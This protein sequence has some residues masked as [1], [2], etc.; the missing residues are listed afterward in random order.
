MRGQYP[1]G[2]RAAADAA[3]HELDDVG[4]LRNVLTLGALVGGSVLVTLLALEIGVR[5]IGALDRNSIERLA[6][7]LPVEP[8]REL[9]MADLIR[10]SDDDRIVYELRPGTL[11]RFLGHEVRI[12]AL[13]MRDRPR[14]AAK[15]AGVFRI[16]VL[17]DSQLFGWGVGQEESFAPVLESLLA[18]RDP[19]RFEV[20]NAG[21]PGYNTVMEARVF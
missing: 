7:D 11:G 17:G 16:L 21:V 13:G 15:P 1:R 20:L 18:A 14:S 8:G 19:H 2:R 5:V 10:R 3:G 6:D 12:I 4:R 9:R